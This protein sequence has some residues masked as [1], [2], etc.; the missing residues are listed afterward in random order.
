MDLADITDGLEIEDGAE[1]PAVGKFGSA[2][3][4]TA[5]NELISAVQE[6][7]KW[8]IK[9]GKATK[10]THVKATVTTQYGDESSSKEYKVILMADAEDIRNNRPQGSGGSGGGGAKG[11]VTTSGGTAA[12]IPGMTITNHESIYD[13]YRKELDG[14][15]GKNE[16]QSMIDSGIITGDGVSLHLNNTVTRAEVLKMIVKAFGYEPI[17][18]SGGYRD[19]KPEDWFSDYAEVAQKYGIMSGD[20]DVFRGNQP[21]SRQ[22]MAVVLV[23]VLRKQEIALS[24][25]SSRD[26][27]DIADVASWALESVNV[28]SSFG[29]IKGYETGDFLPINSLKRDESMVVVYRAIEFVKNQSVEVAE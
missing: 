17:K 1:I 12:V 29:L 23:N 15:W 5:D 8:V 28:A 22:E 25:D 11:S 21:I 2:V 27:A 13:V 18:Y 7:D 16:I 24:T 6:D 20:G 3:S 9:I 19:V 10:E 26:F 4:V 14:H